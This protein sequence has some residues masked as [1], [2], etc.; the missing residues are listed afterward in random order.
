MCASSYMCVTAPEL[1]GPSFSGTDRLESPACFKFR[2]NVN[3]LLE[4]CS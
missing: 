2:R 4:N 1:R 3:P